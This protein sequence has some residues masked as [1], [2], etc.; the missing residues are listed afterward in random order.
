MHEGAA[1]QIAAAAALLLRAPDERT[2][3]L[4]AGGPADAEAVAAARQD[5]WDV[6]C[7]PQSGRFVPPYEHVLRNAY[8]RDQ[9]WFFPPA[10]YDGGDGVASVYAAFGFEPRKLDIEPVWAVAHLPADHIGFMLAFVAWALGALERMPA[11]E[12]ARVRA[13]AQAQAELAR[14]VAGHLGKWTTLYADLLA[15]RGGAF[16]GQVS[17]AVREAVELARQASAADEPRLEGIPA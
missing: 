7:I 2:V 9:F 12:E 10:R 3:G 14:F 6:L 16:L 11:G 5:Y 1:S 8:R 15:D 13:Q 4:L 17:R